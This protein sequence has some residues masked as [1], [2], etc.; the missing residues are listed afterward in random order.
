MSV[1]YA[2][3][4][5]QDAATYTMNEDTSKYCIQ[6]LR[7]EKGDEVLLADGRGHKITALIT[8]DNRK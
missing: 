2:P 3:E 1:F 8:D 6:V 4:I 5:Q 7:H